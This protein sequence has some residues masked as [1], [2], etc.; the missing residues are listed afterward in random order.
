MNHNVPDNL[1]VAFLPLGDKTIASSRLRCHVIQAALNR[2]GHY[3]CIGC[4]ESA[5]VLCIQKRTDSKAIKT[6]HHWKQKGGTLLFDIDDFPENSSFRRGVRKLIKLAD[7]VT[8]ATPEQSE[9]IQKMFP[10]VPPQRIYC[11]PNPV[12]YSPVAPTRKRHGHSVPLKVVWFGNVENFPE[13]LISTICSV[14]N[15]EMHIITHL[16]DELIKRYSSSVIFHEWSYETFSEAF[17]QFD[18]CILSHQGSS[19][20]QAKNAHKM[21]TAIIHGLPV[22]ASRTPDHLRVAKLA[23]VD[24]LLFESEEDMLR[25]LEYFKKPGRR[26]SYLMTAQDAIWQKFNVEAVTT[27]FISVV[28][29]V[30]QL[31]RRTDL[32]ALYA[33]TVDSWIEHWR[34][35]ER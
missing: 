2:M 20:V 14:P 34:S 11:F 7:A 17:T 4:D 1:R 12:D 23:G 22:L 33:K 18:V 30:L 21:I 24:D 9:L 5:S 32:H 6:A 15:I 27:E 3:A 29:Q 28:Q 16:S 19:V 10:C 35:Y 13:A 26:T 25:L 8:T 31:P